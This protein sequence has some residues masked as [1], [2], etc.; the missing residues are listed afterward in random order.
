MGLVF[1][2]LCPLTTLKNTLGIS[3]SLTQSLIILFTTQSLH[4]FL[5]GST[6]QAL[7]CLK[8]DGQSF[9]AVF[10]VRSPKS[11]KYIS[12][13]STQGNVLSLEISCSQSVIVLFTTQNF[14]QEAHGLPFQEEQN[15]QLMWIILFMQYVFCSSD[16]IVAPVMVEQFSCALRDMVSYIGLLVLLLMFDQVVLGLCHRVQQIM[17]S[18][19]FALHALLLSL[20]CLVKCHTPTYKRAVL[21]FCVAT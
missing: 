2:F 11:A 19:V 1:L 10:K 17:S 20:T 16:F 15:N 6:K 8:L 4:H 9:A 7:L 18:N 5:Q 21:A 3:S 14:E 13:H 12:Y